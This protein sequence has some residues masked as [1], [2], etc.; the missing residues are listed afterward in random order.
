MNVY[1]AMKTIVME[2]S[3][4]LQPEVRPSAKK[5]GDIVELELNET[6]HDVEYNS[7][8]AAHW[9]K[10]VHSLIFACA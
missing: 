5:I 9:V 3:Y 10:V 1:L 6:L 2:P 8:E 4:R 7:S